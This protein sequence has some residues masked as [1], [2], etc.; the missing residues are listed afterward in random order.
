MLSVQVK[1]SKIFHTFPVS[2]ARLCINLRDYP[3]TI[4]P[5]C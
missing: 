2:C 5:Y 4:N 3:Y 1:D